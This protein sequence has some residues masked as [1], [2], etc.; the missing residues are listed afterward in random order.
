MTKLGLVILRIYCH[1]LSTLSPPKFVKLS[2]RF[3]KQ[4]SLVGNALELSTVL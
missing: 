2:S 4:F 3:S 1:F